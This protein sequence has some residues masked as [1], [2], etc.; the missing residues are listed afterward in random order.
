MGL[1]PKKGFSESGCAGCSWSL[2]DYSCESADRLEG[3][4]VSSRDQWWVVEGRLGESC[5][6]PVSPTVVGG[7]RRRV[8]TARLSRSAI[9]NNNSV[10]KAPACYFGCRRWSVKIARAANGRAGDCD[11]PDIWVV[12]TRLRPPGL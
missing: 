8:T 5:S 2:S 4:V 10:Q 7:G 11:H 9:I 12:G 1:L 3:A 6:T